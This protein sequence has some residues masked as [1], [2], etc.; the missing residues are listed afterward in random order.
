MR[1]LADA[2]LTKL[3]QSRLGPWGPRVVRIS[4]ISP[5]ASSQS[6]GTIRPFTFAPTQRWPTSVWTRYAKSTGVEPA[7]RLYTS[8]LGENTKTSS[9]KMSTF[10]ASTK[11]SAS[12]TSFCHS[13]SS[14][15]QLSLPS[16]LGSPPP[17]L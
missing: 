9:W 10:T 7:G 6:S 5:F 3:S 11:D 1:S 17:S 14:R 12:M 2:L 16:N 15:S 4:T 8:P 13:I